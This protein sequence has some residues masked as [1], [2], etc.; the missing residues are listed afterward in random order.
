MD[1]NGCESE[2]AARIRE[3][4]RS[5]EIAKQNLYNGRYKCAYTCCDETS[6]VRGLR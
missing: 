4:D 6:A 1:L 3:S 5:V 2:D